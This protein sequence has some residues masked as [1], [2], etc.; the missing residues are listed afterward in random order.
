MVSRISRKLARAKQPA[1]QIITQQ[2]DG[3][4]FKAPAA[5]PSQSTARSGNRAGKT[6]NARRKLA[7]S[8]VAAPS[9][10]SGTAT[11]PPNAAAEL[12]TRTSNSPMQVAKAVRRA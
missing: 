11:V 8:S 4:R 5:S 10:P 12:P 6:Q 1:P 2:G 7:V 9:R 3:Y